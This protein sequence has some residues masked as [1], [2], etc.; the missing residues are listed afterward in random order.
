MD[1]NKSVTAT[2][3]ASP[4]FSL[5]G[6]SLSPGTVTAGQSSTG[7]VTVNP[8]SGFN[9]TV[10]FSC[11]VQPSP[12]HA[13]TCAVTPSGSGASVTVMT[14]A[15]SFAG[16]AS[17]YAFWFYAL[18]LPLIGLV[19][20]SFRLVRKSKNRAGVLLMVAVLLG[21]ITFQLACGGTSNTQ[22]KQLSGGTPP[23]N[24]TITVMGT[25]GSLQ[26]ST[27]FALTVQ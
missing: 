16:K 15:P 2:F 12:S 20:T 18:W 27:N 24:Y 17:R 7:T 4:D 14:T 10:T 13:P 23:G 22:V 5:A 26:H 21:G 9:G 1:S 3:N 8:S 11:S 6:S 19:S 25:S